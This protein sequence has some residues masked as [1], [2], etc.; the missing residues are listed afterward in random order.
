MGT[1]GEFPQM[2]GGISRAAF[3]QV[4]KELEAKAAMEV[5]DRMRRFVKFL[6]LQN[7]GSGMDYEKI[8]ATFKSAF[9]SLSEEERESLIT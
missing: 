1:N 8:E 2:V 6:L 7:A 3:Y 5:A 4:K 9:A